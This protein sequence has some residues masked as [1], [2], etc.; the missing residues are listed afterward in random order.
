MIGY[1]TK[2]MKREMEKPEYSKEALGRIRIYAKGHER[3]IIKATILILISVIAGIGSYGFCYGLI[4]ELLITGSNNWNRLYHLSALVGF[5]GILKGIFY[6]WGLN[7]SH[8]AAYNI[9]Y[10][11][12][13]KLAEKIVKIPLGDIQAMGAGAFKRKMVEDIEHVELIIAHLIPEGLPY[14]TSPLIVYPIIFITD[15]RMGLLALGS[16]PF[17]I[18]AMSMMN[19][20]APGRME[21][22]Y[23]TANT[24]NKIIVDYVSG[25]EV[26]K[27][28]GRT[29][30]SYERYVD[31]ISDYS[32]TVL[33]WFQV[34]LP[35]MALYSVMVPATIMLQLPIGIYLFLS[36]RLEL[37]IFIFTIMMSMSLGAPLTKLMFFGGTIPN[38][39]QRI[40][41]MEKM[42]QN[43]ELQEGS[44]DIDTRDYT[45]KFNNVSFA[46]E[47]EQ[48]IKKVSFTIAPG[49]LTAIVG[50]SGSGKS[51]LAKLLLHYWDVD[52][53]EILIGSNHIQD[54]TIEKLMEHISYVSQDNFLFNMSLM[55][56]IR[57]GR[58]EATDEEV[59]QAS[60]LAQCHE[61]IK[62]L[63]DKYDSNA[64]DAGT[65]LSG[66]QIQRVTLAR[67][68]L[69]D[70]PIIVL[71]EATAYAD[72]E[73]EDKIHDAIRALT[74]EKTVIVIAHRLST[75]KNADQIIV[76]KSGEV[77]EINT[78][79]KLLETCPEYQK[80]W[81]AH[82]RSMKWTID[83][84]E[85]EEVQ[86]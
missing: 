10:E 6:N 55:D 18:L 4:N 57:V 53:G 29:V 20:L 8:E 23:E 54:T 21:K 28:F 33:E 44:Q 49:T 85:H 40:A 64:G 17:G 67:A 86:Q 1:K 69:R 34:S 71:D 9:L 19:R 51:T 62:D 14:M 63:P 42:F 61:F 25:I 60:K 65:K 46:Y 5:C 77:Q 24:M 39:S 13:K 59:I 36:G 80:L 22:V 7:A 78:H 70:A 27:I 82:Q 68:I 41:E 52:D 43:R 76:L 37:N 81:R 48:V 30:D 38:L 79:E 31:A 12:R 50:E 3:K 72:P 84:S 16:L 58:L 47:Q 2:R 83:Y 45:I 32:N 56:N 75:I 15:W 26:I 73:N 66:G 11:M 74:Q 35:W